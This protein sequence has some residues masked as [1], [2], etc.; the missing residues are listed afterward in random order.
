MKDF[1]ISVGF[2]QFKIDHCTFIRTDATNN[3][4]TAIHVHINNL[5][6]TGNNIDHFKKQISERWEM[7]HLGIAKVFVGIEIK[8]LGEHS[9]RLTQSRFTETILKRFDMFKTKSAS[10]P[11]SPGVKLRKSTDKELEEVKD[12]KLPYCNAVGS[13]MYLAQCTRPD[14]GH[15]V[16]VLSQ[17]L[18]QPSRKY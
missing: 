11:L 18:E 13:L 6:I 17:H 15:A 3:K 2:V 16:G 9:Y 12:E 5:A 10:T 14:L 8:R 4:F 1:L 7:E